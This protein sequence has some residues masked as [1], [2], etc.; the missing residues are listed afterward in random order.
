MNRPSSRIR[1]DGEALLKLRVQQNLTQEKLA[2]MSDLD[3]RTVQRA[4]KG[5]SLQLETIVG[6]ATALKVTVPELSMSGDESNDARGL[7]ENNQDHSGDHDRNT[8]VL[9][10]VAS[11]KVL[12]DILSDSFSG[13]LSC[14]VDP[15]SENVEALTAIVE[16]IERFIPN[17][18]ATPMERGSMTLAERLRTAVALTAK[19]TALEAFDVAVF[20]GIYPARA[21]VP[22]YDPDE[23]HMY[24]TNRTP[25][26]PVTICRVMLENRNRDR[27][28]VK[29][30]DKWTEPSSPNPDSD[31]IPF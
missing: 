29:V 18:W 7:D 13:K 2:T 27:V 31:D 15:T 10:R 12:L 9:R 16:E 6:L 17:P 5:E 25:F 22:S 4:E 28:V 11:G 23:G 1:C 8:V 21:Q 19:L 24:T 14:E 20:A 3:V 26:R 30:T